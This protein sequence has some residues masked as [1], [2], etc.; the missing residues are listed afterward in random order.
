LHLLQQFRAHGGKRAVLAGSCFEYDFDHGYCTEDL[1]PTR[2]NTFYG[3]AK[4]SLS[5]LA[6]GYAEATGLSVA[7]AR[8]FFVYGPGQPASNLIPHVIE[9]LLDGEVAECTHGRQVR[10]YLHVTDVASACTA[11][12]KSDVEGVVNV[13]S[14]EPTQLRDMIHTVADALD[15][16]SL[17]A[18]GAR[19]PQ[20]GESPLLLANSTRLR[21]E[22]G[23]TPSFTMQTGLLDT[24][25]WWKKTQTPDLIPVG[26]E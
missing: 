19:D 10:D 16:R 17:V 12:L 26:K 1:T 7:T 23:W 8:I 21:D 6:H 11:L 9:S 20:P 18:L 3:Q 4:N 22:V 25:E 24:V 5:R 14:G 15:A 2:P 13:G